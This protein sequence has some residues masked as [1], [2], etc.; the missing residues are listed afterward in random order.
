[1]IK[2]RSH[3]GWCEW[4]AAQMEEGTITTYTLWSEDV[5]GLVPV[6]N[7]VPGCPP[8]AEALLYGILQALQKKIKRRKD[9]FHW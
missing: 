5:I 3:V 2:C 4:G 1:M 8:M 7:Y 6:D 9:F